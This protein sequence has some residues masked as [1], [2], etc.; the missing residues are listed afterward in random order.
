MARR[1]WSFSYKNVLHTLF[2]IEILSLYKTVQNYTLS[3]SQFPSSRHFSLV[4]TLLLCSF[5]SF[6]IMLYVI[7]PPLE[8]QM[9]LFSFPKIFLCS[10]YSSHYSY[11]WVPGN[12]F[13]YC[14]HSFFFFSRKETHIHIYDI[15]N[16]NSSLNNLWVFSFT[17]QVY[18]QIEI[19]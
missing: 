9:Q 15:N 5:V 3:P 7:Y 13:F 14:S 16:S 1:N 2:F 8:Y 17:A 18:L 4:F 11:F 6:D 12:F 10:S 19:H